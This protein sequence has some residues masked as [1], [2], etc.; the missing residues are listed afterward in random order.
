MKLPFQKGVLRSRLTGGDVEPSSE[1][2]V[3]DYDSLR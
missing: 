2:S 3:S 1:P